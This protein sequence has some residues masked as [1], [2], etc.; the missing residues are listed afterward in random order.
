MAA[1][2]PLFNA[3][4][5]ATAVSRMGKMRAPPD[6]LAS[7]SQ[8]PAFASLKTAVSAP[9]ASPAS[10]KLLQKPGRACGRSTA[11]WQ[12]GV[13]ASC[14]LKRAAYL[15]TPPKTHQKFDSADVAAQ[16]AKQLPARCV[17]TIVHGFAAM[18]HHPGDAVLAACAAQAAQRINQ[19][20]PLDL[21]NTLW[22]FA[23][24]NFHPG[25][26]LLRACER[27]SVRTANDFI[28][29]N[30]VSVALHKSPCSCWRNCKRPVE[31]LGDMSLLS[32]N[33]GNCACF[34]KSPC[35]A[36]VE[37]LT[38]RAGQRPVGICDLGR[39]HGHRK[40]KC[41]GGD[42]AEAATAV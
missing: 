42:S 3:V 2:L 41:A 4:N 28:P 5:L 40:L 32:A 15:N 7:A 31:A 1:S 21:A 30:T 19:A 38:L 12:P 36:P 18:D 16:R 35:A 29:R 11:G 22:G 6:V 39:A 20:N 23:R 33:K 10:V 24:L 14:G 8:H 13:C 34:G 9:H 26:E 25:Y 27:A 17:A 37:A